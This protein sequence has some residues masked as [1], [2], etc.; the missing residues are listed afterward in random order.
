MNDDTK[1]AFPFP[2]T[3]AELKVTIENFGIVTADDESNL[4]VTGFDFILNREADTQ[5]SEYKLAVIDSIIMTLFNLKD[6]I[7]SKNNPVVLTS[8]M[9]NQ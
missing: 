4:V 7:L 2:P 3:P 5:S 8:I 9:I 6:S 1:T